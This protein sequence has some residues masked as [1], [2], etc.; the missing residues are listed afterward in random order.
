M[1]S[2]EMVANKARYFFSIVTSASSV[3]IPVAKKVVKYASF[4]LER[5]PSEGV[6]DHPPLSVVGGPVGLG[7]VPEH[8]TAG[9]GQDGVTLLDGVEAG[10]G[11]LPV[12]PLEAA[13]AV[14]V[15]EL[16]AVGRRV[17]RIV[18]SVGENRNQN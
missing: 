5:L 8:V 3:K 1:S 13:G 7:G 10:A 15:L 4:T 17:R 6:D 11:V 9:A 14:E 2:S 18:T 16:S 12:V